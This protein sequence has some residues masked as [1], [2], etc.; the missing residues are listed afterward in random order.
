MLA[1]EDYDGSSQVAGAFFAAF[2]V[3]AVLGSLV[4]IRIVPRYDPVRLGAVSLV[5]LTL[6]LWLL[7][8]DLPAVGVMACFSPRRSSGR[9]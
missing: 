6:P 2:G 8:F 7:A 4:A 3:G 9:S 1:Y 5:A